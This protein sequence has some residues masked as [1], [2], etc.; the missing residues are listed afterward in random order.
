MSAPDVDVIRCACGNPVSPGVVSCEWCIDHDGCVVPAG[1]RVYSSRF[2]GG[3]VAT[4]R[5]CGYMWG[6]W[7]CPC[8][9]SHTCEPV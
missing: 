3:P 9:L 4:C 7:D 6:Y 8:E 1:V 5:V 2:S